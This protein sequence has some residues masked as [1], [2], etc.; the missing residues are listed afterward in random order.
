MQNLTKENK[1][2]KSTI[3]ELRQQ[4]H[5]APQHNLPSS[6]TNNNTVQTPS[7]TNLIKKAPQGNLNNNNNNSQSPRNHHRKQSF[8]NTLQINKN[9]IVNYNNRSTQQALKAYDSTDLSMPNTNIDDP[10][11]Q[12][13]G[14]WK[15]ANEKPKNRQQPASKYIK[16]LG[17][18]RT[19][20]AKGFHW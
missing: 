11:N 13:N 20:I 16:T 2:L 8:A 5:Y 9:Q 18:G 3:G 6:S 14:P 12:Y 1:E 4:K 19:A 10:N 17:T 7:S 15:V